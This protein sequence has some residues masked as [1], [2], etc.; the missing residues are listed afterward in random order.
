MP[1][2]L[3]EH[4]GTSLPSVPNDP[5]EKFAAA[6]EANVENEHSLQQD[7]PLCLLLRPRAG[8][9]GES[10]CG[11]MHQPASREFGEEEGLPLPAKNL[12]ARQCDRRGHC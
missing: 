9:D 3:N 11:E 12:R 8:G 1:L 10:G 5:A 4:D 6:A 2:E 7:A